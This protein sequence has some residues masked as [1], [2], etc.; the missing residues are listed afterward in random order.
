MR[1]ADEAEFR[2]F[3]TARLPILRK[4]AFLLCG[5]R[6]LADDL[7]ATTILKLYRNWRQ[8]QR[9]ERPDAYLRRVLI[10]TWLDELRRP[11]RR[12]QPT[13]ELP[14]P[15][16][17]LDPEQADRVTLLAM[18]A[19]LPPR[20]RAVIVLR[21]YEGHDIEETARILGVATGTVKAHTH[22]ALAQLRVLF[23]EPA[24]QAGKNTWRN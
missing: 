20:R 6:Y 19:Q 24:Q 18:L 3:V 9:S 21:Y 15:A 12:E 13:A 17:H 22:H 10:N 16:A 23:E 11:W 2:E 8:L 5:D 4:S 7:A 14:E 1:Q